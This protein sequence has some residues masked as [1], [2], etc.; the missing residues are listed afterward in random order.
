WA[1]GPGR[2]AGAAAEAVARPGA[3]AGADGAV[4]AGADRARAGAAAAR[5]GA[6]HA[7]A[8]AAGHLARLIA[9]QAALDV[10]I[11]QAGGEIAGRGDR[12]ERP[13]LL[14]PQHAENAGGARPLA[15]LPPRQLRVH[16]LDLLDLVL[17]GLAGGVLLAHLAFFEL[18]PLAG[19]AR[20]DALVH[21][22][23]LLFLLGLLR[24]LDLGA[25]VAVLAVL[26]LG[27]VA[28]R[29]A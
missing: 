22:L 24:R 11:V 7:V 4:A 18:H 16:A 3:G 25:G 28:A 8:P 12:C 14:R 6:R 26:V 1:R 17:A 27:E 29:G 2:A 10:A 9:E 19:A 13:A 23:G 20:H 5:A 21:V 15:A